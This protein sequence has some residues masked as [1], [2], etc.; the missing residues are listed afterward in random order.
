[1]EGIFLVFL[2]IIK[3][4]LTCEESNILIE[5]AI[6]ILSIPLIENKL[7]N[8]L[9]SKIFIK[10]INEL[11]N[12]KEDK[13]PLPKPVKIYIHEKPLSS[14][15]CLLGNIISLFINHQKSIE[16]DTLVCKNSF[17]INKNIVILFENCK[18]IF[19]R[20]SIKISY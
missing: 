11:N 2:S 5:F 13:K 12:W 19:E 1:M 3:Q 10:L 18:Y 16:N 15:V 14:K 9:D 6:Q 20:C 4:I 7:K 8:F 17:S